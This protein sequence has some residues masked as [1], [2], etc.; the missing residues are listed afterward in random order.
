MI[1]TYY[2]V[3]RICHKPAWIFT[4]TNRFLLAEMAW[5]DFFPHWGFIFPQAW[6]NRIFSS[7]R[8]YFSA[9]PTWSSNRG[10]EWH[11]PRILWA[12]KQVIGSGNRTLDPQKDHA[13]R[14][15]NR[16]LDQQKRSCARPG[17]RTLDRLKRSF[18]RSCTRSLNTIVHTIVKFHVRTKYAHMH[19]QV[20]RGTCPLDDGRRPDR[21]KNGRRTDRFKNDETFKKI[22]SLQ[23]ISFLRYHIMYQ[24][25]YIFTGWISLQQYVCRI[26]TEKCSSC[27]ITW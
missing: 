9:K 7:W 17:V 15:G 21:P 11:R 6:L 22:C 4:C 16:T 26:R 20:P 1:N 24:V 12:W 10:G 23:N 8:F 27:K 14:S 2:H 25:M 3:C 13:A 19:E 5:Q 18:V